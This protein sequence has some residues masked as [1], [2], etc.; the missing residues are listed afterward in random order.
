MPATQ[1]VLKMTFAEESWIEIR[2][3]GSRKMIFF[4]LVAAG[5]EREITGNLPLKVKIGNAQAAT[6]DFNGAAVNLIPY[7]QAGVARLLLQ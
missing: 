3:K 2:E 5:T 7:T 4:E 6:L 1:G